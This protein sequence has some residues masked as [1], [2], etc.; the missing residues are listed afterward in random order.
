[1]KLFDKWISSS[2]ARTERPP[3]III[4]GF[5]IEEIVIA[6]NTQEGLHHYLSNLAFLK[7]VIRIFNLL[8][9]VFILPWYQ[10]GDRNFRL[11]IW[12]LENGE[13]D[14]NTWNKDTVDGTAPYKRK[15]NFAEY[16]QVSKLGNQQQ[17][18]KSIFVQHL[19]YLKSF[20]F[21]FSFKL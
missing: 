1:M 13:T 20:F 11:L 18:H 7:L 9:L 10:L 4:T 15:I 17:N 12:I 3:D 8:T 2:G 14:V 21:C 16:F 19:R 6:N 5:G